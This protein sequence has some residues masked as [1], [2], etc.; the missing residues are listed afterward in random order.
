VALEQTSR[1]PPIDTILFNGLSV[2][3]GK[4]YAPVCLYSAE[5]HRKVIE[6][7]LTSPEEE[8]ED[9]HKLEKALEAVTIDLEKISLTAAKNMG[10]VEAEI[11]VTQKHIV[12]DPLLGKKI[13]DTITTEK[14]NVESAVHQVF[15]RYEQE[16]M[17]L[18][19]AYMRERASDISDIRRRI[20][21]Q[22]YD[23][24]PGFACEGQAHCRR[25]KDRIIVA[26]E[27]TAEMI[28]HM[29][30]ERVM[31]FVTEHGG[32]SSHAA[33][34]ARSLGIPSVTG[35]HGILDHVRC[36]DRVLVD[37]DS[38]TV[39]LKPDTATVER[40]V[41]KDRISKEDVRILKSPPGTEVL[42]NASLVDDVTLARAVRAD[43]IGLLR[44][45]IVFLQANRLLSEDE[46]Y[47][48]Y[49]HVVEIMSGKPV[50]FRLLDVGGDKPLS[51]LRIEKEANPY[52]GWRGARFLL[53]S[54]DIMAL[55]VRAL[56]RVSKMHKIRIMIPMVVDGTQAKELRMLV[57]DQ[58][59][60]VDAKPENIELG[61]MFEIPSACLMAKEIFG[62]MDFGSIGSNDLIQ[63][64]FAVDRNNERVSADFNPE[65][66]ALW[67]MLRQLAAAA[68]R[69]KKPL[70]IC[71]EMAGREGTPQKLLDI[72]I[73]SMS[74]SPRL[75]TRVR[76]EVIKHAGHSGKLNRYRS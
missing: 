26:E 8:L 69:A 49:L 27:L 39:Y 65:H 23:L 11:F 14:R 6:T 21:D 4:I 9:L 48:F 56:A 41:P 2:N 24:R 61:A 53:G 67:N 30:L 45:E 58:V 37:G 46:Q 74:V 59:A 57:N 28:V 62:H 10:K 50:T 18:D 1:K 72:G 51:F 31:G 33:I 55:Q 43:G 47:D 3:P 60:T 52:L 17:A 25:G 44:T 63:Y 15:L 13:R 68:K 20:L 54:P 29:Q 64:L 75:V 40:M 42:A 66:P 71:G 7:K 36:G 12:N 32:L 73:S 70:S 22:L 76:N 34:I 5:R 38:G 35:V 19:D 16:F